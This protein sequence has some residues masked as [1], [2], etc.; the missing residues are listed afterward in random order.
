M[1]KERRYTLLLKGK[2]IMSFLLVEKKSGIYAIPSTEDPKPH[3]HIYLSDGRLHRHVTHENYPLGHR[4]RHTQKRSISVEDF[5]YPIWCSMA[6]PDDPPPRV[7]S[8]ANEQESAELKKWFARIGPKLVHPQSDRP[9]RLLKGPFGALLDQSAD[10]FAVEFGVD[11]HLEISQY[12]AY[13]RRLK[14]KS[15]AE[16]FEMAK[17]SDL[18]MGG[19][20]IG[21]SVDLARLLILVGDGFIVELPWRSLEK[22]VNMQFKSLGFDGFLRTLRRGRASVRQSRR[23]S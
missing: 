6:P 23:A 22:A 18:S 19:R 16:L 13:Y 8:F 12:L 4:R 1:T 10:K 5:A 15:K 11:W 21:F 17:E 14:P 20:R 9:I 3:L 7:S 2:T